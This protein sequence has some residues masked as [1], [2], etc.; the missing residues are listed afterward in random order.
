MGSAL[1]SLARMLWTIVRHPR[2]VAQSLRI[3]DDVHTISTSPEVRYLVEEIA[4]CPACEPPVARCDVH[5]EA[6][7][8]IVM[9]DGYVGVDVHRGDGN[10]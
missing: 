3:A 7:Q 2:L 8:D 5:E 1:R 10:E 6:W 9:P 4:D